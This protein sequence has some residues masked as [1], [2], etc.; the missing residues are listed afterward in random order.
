MHDELTPIFKIVNE[1][2][3]KITKVKEENQIDI[4]RDFGDNPSFGALRKK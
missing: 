2:N 3:A 1:I 4:P